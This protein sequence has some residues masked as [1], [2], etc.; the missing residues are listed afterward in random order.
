MLSEGIQTLGRL[1]RFGI[2]K[3]TLGTTEFCKIEELA[4]AV[5]K[6]TKFVV[7]ELSFMIEKEWF[8]EGHLDK[9]KTCLF[10]SNNAYQ[11]YELLESRHAVEAGMN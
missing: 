1:K 10:V 11:K 6:T 2:Y 8:C 9:Q 4:A 7:K 5:Q 3:D